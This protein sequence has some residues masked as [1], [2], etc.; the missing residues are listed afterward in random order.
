M[1]AATGY[2]FATCQRGTAVLAASILDAASSGHWVFDPP[3]VRKSWLNWMDRVF[4]RALH[5]HPEMGPDWFLALF[6]TTTAE[7]MARFMNDVPNLNDAFCVA[8]ALP[9]L[10]FLRASLRVTFR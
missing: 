10:P 9:K 5:R 8:V 4:L 7:Q 6:R 3:T 2:H 1:R